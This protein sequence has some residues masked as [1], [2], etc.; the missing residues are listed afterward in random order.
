MP[1]ETFLAAAAEGPIALDKTGAVTSLRLESYDIADVVNLELLVSAGIIRLDSIG[2]NGF[3][4]SLKASSGLI[5]G[6]MIVPSDHLQTSDEA[7]ETA[8]ELSRKF[9][10]AGVAGQQKFVVGKRDTV[11]S[12]PP[13]ET[14]SDAQYALQD[15]DQR[16]A[17]MGI[18]SGK[19]NEFY[20]GI[21]LQNYRRHRELDTSV[22]LARQPAE[23][24][25]SIQ[26]APVR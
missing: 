15:E 4:P 3:K 8:L 23:W 13:V 25:V 9:I 7:L 6:I 20:V 17:Q 21:S 22:R 5:D 11:Q 24:I 16:V 1:V 26:L 10:A 14:A 2:G 18:F 19:T 12:L